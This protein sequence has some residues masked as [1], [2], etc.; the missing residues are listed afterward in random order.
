MWRVARHAQ[1]PALRRHSSTSAS[2]KLFAD[3][4][5]EEE[6]ERAAPRA[7]SR[8][9][10][11]VAQHVEPV[12]TGDE[13]M[14]D[15][16]LRMLLDKY[17]PMRSGSKEDGL[18]RRLQQ[19]KPTPRT[20]G[21]APPVPDKPWNI[22]FVGLHTP[23]GEPKVHRGKI[24]PPPTR[25][26]RVMHAR[27]V[28]QAPI[29]PGDTRAKTELKKTL[30]RIATRDRIEA[31]VGA[32]L[33]YAKRPA[34]AS[35]HDLEHEREQPLIVGGQRGAAALAERRIQEA[36]QSGAFAHNSLRGKEMPYDSAWNSPHLGTEEFLMNRI[37][38]RQGAAPPWVE[39]N[40]AVQT[41][42]RLLRQA[43][44]HAW[45]CRALWR[46]DVHSSALAPV[47]VHWEPPRPPSDMPA[48]SYSA[49]DEAEH[50]TVRWAR[51]F[52]D[53]AWV[54]REAAYH[55]AAVHTLNET[56]RRYNYIAPPTAR[57]M[58]QT[59]AKF[60]E[61]ALRGAEPLIVEGASARLRG[62]RAAPP[63]PPPP[64]QKKGLFAWLF[65]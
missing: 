1:L 36:F 44:Q 54:R 5:E 59:R 4:L 26:D 51:A 43:I 53:D 32:S 48:F 14:E 27:G 23:G 12:W 13:R 35:L 6:R 15:T 49:A 8:A 42:A 34:N 39:L 9:E 52:R 63:P 24:A 41:E 25:L 61:D 3:A 57:K 17:K 29:K 7:A 60:V 10:Q 47:H 50:A 58:L 62:R 31:A 64:P 46:L 21:P 65:T 33:D 40:A 38:R 45:V 56:I 28:L 22:T 55:D 11:L 18:A 30:G 19:A 2:Q 20:P 37:V 16:V